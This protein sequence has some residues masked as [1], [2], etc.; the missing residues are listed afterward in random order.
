MLVCPACGT[1]NPDG[2]KFCLEC[3][4]ALAGAEERTDERKLVTVLFADVVGS[5]SLG[6]KLDAEALKDI[7]SRFF[8]AMREEIES[9]GG[10][11]EKFIGDA[12][13]AAFGVPAA[14]EDDP[15]RALRAA[16][17]M[18]RRLGELNARLAHEHGVQ[19]A[20]RVGVNTGEVVAT[21]SPRPGE[22]M[23]TGDPVNM[24][25]RL[26]SLAEPGSVLVGARTAAAA[27]GFALVPMASLDVRGRDDPLPAFRLA[28]ESDEPARGIPGLRAPMVGRDRELELLG[29]LLRRVSDEGRGH[30]VTIYGD[31]GV[32]K[33]RLVAEFTATAEARVVIGRCLPYGDGITFWPLVEIAKSEFGL[34]DTDTP[35]A[36]LA[37]VRRLEMDAPELRDAVP[38]IAYTIGLDDAE[39]PLRALSPRA[40][41]SA[42]RGAWRSLFAHMA[43]DGPLVVVVEDIHWADGAMLDLLEE[44]A[45]RIPAPV[46]FLCPSRPELTARRPGWGG[47]RRSVSSIALDP[48]GRAEAERM[49]ELLLNVDELDDGVRARI[50]ERAEGNPFFLEEI[51]RRLMDEQL[52]V[53]EGGRW[54]ADAAID[55]V[56][57]PDTVQ[58]VLAARIDL[59]PADQKRAVQ[60]AAVVGRVFWPGAVAGLLDGDA[61]RVEQLLDELERRDLVLTRLTSSMAG[62]RELIFKHILTRDVAYE[63]LPRKERPRAHGD[64]AAWIERTYGERRLEVAELLAHH[65]DLAGDR[66]RARRYALDAGRRD[67]GRLALDGALAFATRAAELAQRPVDRAAALAVIGEAR[68][69]AANGDAAFAAWHEAVRLLEN[70]PNDDPALVASVCGRLAMLATRAPGLMPQ[71]VAD[72]D[73]IRRVLEMG[74]AAAGDGDSPA[75]VDLLMADGAWGFGFPDALAE[76]RERTLD[77]MT[78]AGRQAVAMAERLGQPEL[79]SLALDVAYIADQDRDDVPTLLAGVERRLQLADHVLAGIDLDDIFYMAAQTYWEQGR[80]RD[81]LAVAEEGVERVSALGAEPIG[82]RSTAAITR[83]LL[84]DWDAVVDEHRSAAAR[85][86]QPPGFLRLLWATTE[87]VYAARG[88]ID[89]AS[90]LREVTYGAMN[91]LAFR[92]LGLLAEGRL[93]EAFAQLDRMRQPDGL[94]FALQ[95]R[96]ELLR[97]ARRW[98]DLAA[99]IQTIRDRSARIGWLIGPPAADRAEAAIAMA[100]EDPAGAEPLLQRSVDGFREAG[101]EWEAARSAL[102]LA[103]ALQAIGHAD[104][105]VSALDDASPAL[106]RAGAVAELARLAELRRA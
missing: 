82:S 98:D 85:W 4:T 1:R 63:S 47:G 21:T 12:V 68:Y 23:A 70:Q 79:L 32:G 33:S 77:R 22:A 46:L 59:L 31:P 34:L 48:L 61:D 42:I 50:L 97:A 62:Q 18:Q 56:A 66:E 53:Q 102:D 89:A 69:Q 60:S 67:L 26:Q 58:G 15:E 94:G 38:A 10:A 25:A 6:G 106:E 8:S 81:A 55:R 105:A 36:A 73:D 57:I 44:L 93:D 19:L 96:A 90:R 104:A 65:Y 75:H 11:V 35:D 71:T 24:A 30:L 9:E 49:V 16:L 45:D 78:E 83:M 43:G 101:A 72:A 95:A 2:A 41:M 5:T 54:R 3:G 7:M 87:Y 29:T 84:G 39:S 51:L 40:V 28:G 99:H 91:R 27:R 76:N 17:R 92:A 64:V 80:Y 86:E 20:M 14:H 13:M 103:A 100:R 74:L 88:D 52:I 37:K